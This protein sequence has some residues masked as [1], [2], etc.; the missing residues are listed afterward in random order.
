MTTTGG[1]QV[2]LRFETA[3][4][5]LVMQLS[6]RGMHLWLQGLV[7]VLAKAEWNLSQALPAWLQSGVLPP[8]VRDMLLPPSV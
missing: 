1:R 8:S 7:M 2:S 5:P 6:R 3:G 4:E